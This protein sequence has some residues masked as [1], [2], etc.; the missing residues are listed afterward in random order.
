[1]ISRRT[2][3]WYGRMVETYIIEFLVVQLVIKLACV[4]H[5]RSKQ[6]EQ[7]YKITNL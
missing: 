7:N 1:M 5:E 6:L 3:D 4:L 2:G